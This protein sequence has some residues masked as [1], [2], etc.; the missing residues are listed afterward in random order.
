MKNLRQFETESQYETVK[1]G[2][3]YPTVSYVTNTDTVHYMEKPPHD[4]SKDYLTFE[5]LEDATISIY[6]FSE[7]IGKMTFYYKVDN[8]NNWQ[9]KDAWYGV[10]ETTD[11]C[12]LLTGQKLQIYCTRNHYYDYYDK[13]KF[14]INNRV[15]ISGNILSIFYGDQFTNYNSFPTPDGTQV[16]S[17]KDLFNSCKIVDASNLIL[18]DTAPEQCYSTMFYRCTSLITAPELP[19]TTLNSGC[20]DSMFQGCTSLITAPTLPATTLETGCYKNMFNGCSSLNYIKAM[21]RTTPSTKYTNN[22]V[23]GVASTGTFVK[24]SA[25]TWN[26]SGVNGIPKGWTVETASA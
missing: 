26:V 21:F 10:G 13:I 9:S 2:F 3:E 15:N 12:S 20:Y 7:S 18:P 11:L 25:A 17:A 14:N 8:E 24:N 5:A 4:Y 22:W 16:A 1:E 6:T 23:K 19:A